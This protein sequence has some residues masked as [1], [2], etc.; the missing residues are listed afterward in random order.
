MTQVSAE[1]QSSRRAIRRGRAHARRLSH[2]PSPEV[3]SFL[4]G[5]ERVRVVIPNG[6]CHGN[7][8]ATITMMRRLREAG[9]SGTYHLLTTP[10]S[11]AKLH[12]LMPGIQPGRTRPQ[13]LPGGHTRLEVVP[14]VRRGLV[15]P[16]DRVELA[17][18]GACDRRSALA[19]E[20]NADSYLVGQPRGWG[21]PFFLM[22]GWNT[23]MTWGDSPGYADSVP[24]PTELDPFLRAQMGH[25]SRFRSKIPLLKQIIEGTHRELVPA[26]G[27]HKLDP[28]WVAPV[29]QALAQTLADRRGL[30][31][32][33]VVM[34]I[35]SEHSIAEQQRIES[36]IRLARLPRGVELEVVGSGGLLRSAPPSGANRRVS[37]VFVGGVTQ[38]VFQYLYSLTTLFAVVEGCNATDLSLRLGIPFLNVYGD[39]SDYPRTADPSL[40]SLLEEANCGGRLAS[41]KPT[42]PNARRDAIMRFIQEIRTE[43]GLTQLFIDEAQRLRAL[44][45]VVDQALEALVRFRGSCP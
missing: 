36:E 44:P 18:S 14:T 4:R 31:A 26:Y 32:P 35:F 37:L 27:L 22:R 11:L 12:H 34:P 16:L 30:L 40:R 17:I 45:D 39:T 2:P 23:G 38:R 7:Q 28:T 13:S 24:A 20:L 1:R 9:F 5:L 3:S 21:N 19:H 15:A 10:L 29:V 43:P 25:H 41:L 42:H 8:S 33:S 6:A